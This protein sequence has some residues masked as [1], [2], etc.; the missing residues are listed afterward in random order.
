MVPKK[1][2]LSR[3]VLPLSYL[4]IGKL[5]GENNG[6][7]LPRWVKLLGRTS[8]GVR[9]DGILHPPLPRCCQNSLHRHSMY[10][11]LFHPAPSLPPSPQVLSWTAKV[12]LPYSFSLTVFCRFLSPLVKCI[13]K[14]SSRLWTEALAFH[15]LSEWQCLPHLS[16]SPNPSSLK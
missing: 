9:K 15:T 3:L 10:P 13:A 11:V 5:R 2:P 1:E 16:P 7:W 14:C 12:A 8:G 4:L 6:Y